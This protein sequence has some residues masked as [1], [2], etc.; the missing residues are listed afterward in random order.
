M[1]ILNKKMIIIIVRKSHLS[2]QMS[3]GCLSPHIESMSLFRAETIDE[4][5]AAI[6]VRL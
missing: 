2:Q 4:G 6:I 5:S 1:G 3:T